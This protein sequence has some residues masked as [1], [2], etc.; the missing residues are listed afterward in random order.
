MMKYHTKKLCYFFVALATSF[1]L[2]SAA[3]LGA[4]GISY[5]NTAVAATKLNTKKI[6][7]PKGSKYTLKITGTS[8]K[9][10]WTTSNK[11]V[12]TVKDGVV[13]TKKAGTTIITATVGSKKYTCKITVL[14]CMINSNNLVLLKGQT[15][16][17]KVT[18]NKKQVTYESSDSN[19]A[20]VNS[21]TGK[22]TAKNYG[23]ATITVKVGTQSFP[24]TVKV[25]EPVL[26]KT[27]ALTYVNSSL[28]LKVN[29]LET[30]K[31]AS[32]DPAIAKVDVSGTV[33]G[34]GVGKTVIT[35]TLSDRVLS[36][37]VTVANRTQISCP[38]SITIGLGETMEYSVTIGGSIKADV[39]SKYVSCSL[40]STYQSGDIIKLK[41][42]GKC[43]G[44]DTI[45]FTCDNGWKKVVKVKVTGTA[46]TTSSVSNPLNNITIS[47][48]Q[49]Y[50][51][52]GSNWISLSFYAK[53]KISQTLQSMTV[54]YTF[55]D[56]KGSELYTDYAT[57][58]NP[59]K[60]KNYFFLKSY[61][62]AKYTWTSDVASVK[63]VDAYGILT[64]K[65]KKAKE[66]WTVKLK[67]IDKGTGTKM[68]IK[69]SKLQFHG[70]KSNVYDF[71][72]RVIR[73]NKG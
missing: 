23:T 31:W 53:N 17:L 15:Y 65:L 9:A 59:K 39:K 64:Q 14:G 41:V 45:T 29:T 61:D 19:I 72:Y 43:V 58:S 36:C 44:N 71:K 52:T 3:P 4:I 5:T 7:V 22:V 20:S 30:I 1:L 47:K 37:T 26:N 50:K 67:F 69:S 12:A 18:K 56:S 49:A 57:V 16:K 48:L 11:S 33:T 13:T 38:D 54:K 32:N 10:K 46:L 73:K 42:L 62:P 70:D 63:I 27:T 68:T 2:V 34:V 55:Y 25:A 51:G 28:R 8:K 6:N 35:A 60:G 40:P 21:K 24:V 66:S